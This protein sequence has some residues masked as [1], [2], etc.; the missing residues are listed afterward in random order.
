MRLQLLDL[1]SGPEFGYDL[2]LELMVTKLPAEGH[3][4]SIVSFLPP[5]QQ[6]TTTASKLARL[7]LFVDWR[8]AVGE[9]N[10]SATALHGGSDAAQCAGVLINE[11]WHVAK[12]AVRFDKTKNSQVHVNIAKTHRPPR[13]E[14]QETE[15]DA[16]S[17]GF[18][19]GSK[20]I[21][22][23][24]AS[25]PKSGGFNFGSASPPKSGGFTFGSAS[26][27]KSGGFN[28]GSAS[29]PKS[30]GFTFGSASPPKF[31]FGLQQSPK[32]VAAAIAAPFLKPEDNVPKPS[33][34]ESKQSKGTV[35]QEDEQTVQDVAPMY[36][37]VRDILEFQVSARTCPPRLISELEFGGSSTQSHSIIRAHQRHVHTRARAV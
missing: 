21:A 33:S 14:E 37:S 3:L 5:K 28:F 20:A 10:S 13:M 32:K 1:G 35:K 24:G 31:S 12:V 26:P 34:A 22:P 15:P 18:P 23:S 16:A 29:P 19:A 7:D 36:R 8:G 27:P 2:Y 11:A 25:P 17:S 6:A 30:G 9:A 4:Q